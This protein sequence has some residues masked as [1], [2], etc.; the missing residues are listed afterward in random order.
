MKELFR[1]ELPKIIVW[2]VAFSGAVVLIALDKVP[3]STLE[4]L[5]FWAAGYTGGKLSGKK[6]DNNAS[7]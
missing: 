3:S 7:S 6:E 1:E 5:L 4:F 2:S